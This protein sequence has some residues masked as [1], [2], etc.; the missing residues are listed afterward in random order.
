MSGQGDHRSVDVVQRRNLRKPG[1]GHLQDRADR[2]GRA[3]GDDGR[4]QLVQQLGR[5]PGAV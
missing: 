2:P 3:S 4:V 1:D 5:G